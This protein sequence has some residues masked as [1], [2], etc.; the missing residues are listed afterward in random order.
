M[1]NLVSKEITEEFW[2]DCTNNQ[3]YSN[4][5]YLKN[6]IPYNQ[7]TKNIGRNNGQKKKDSNQQNLLNLYTFQNKINNNDKTVSKSK[8]KN[9]TTENPNYSRIYKRHP[10]FK[11]YGLLSD[12][13]KIIK[14]RKK[15]ALFRCLGL[16]AYGIEVKKEKLMNEKNTKQERLN[17]ENKKCTFKPK[18]NKYSHSVKPKFLLNF[19]NKKSEKE[20][21]NNENDINKISNLSSYGNVTTRN[22]G[23]NKYNKNH[24]EEKNQKLEDYTFKP[25]TIKLNLKTVFRKSKSI[26]SKNYNNI[27]I[28]RYNKAREKYMVKKIKQL[29]NKDDCYSTM[30]SEFNDFTNRNQMNKKIRFPINDNKNNNLIDNKKNIK[31]DKYIIETLRNQLLDINLSDDE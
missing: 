13:E 18:I 28:W 1:N 9:K 17:A 14:Q 4:M 12:E 27:F 30:V 25:K 19:I 15:E 22:K 21:K 3:I 7:Y 16:Y 11:K 20:E 6:M 2:N 8:S 31:E 29:F 24:E 26:E 5:E 23:N 10:L